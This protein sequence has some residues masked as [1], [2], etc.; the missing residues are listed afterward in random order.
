MILACRWAQKASI[1]AEK[2]GFRRGTVFAKNLGFGVGFGYRNNTRKLLLCPVRSAMYCNQHVCMCFCGCVWLSACIVKIACRYLTRFSSEPI[3]QTASRSVQRFSHRDH[4]VS[5]ILHDGMPF[6][7]KI[8]PS[9]G[10]SGPP[11]NI[12]FLGPTRVLNP[13]GISIGA[14]VFAGF[15]SVTDRQTDRQTDH[16]TR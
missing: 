13:N 5:P 2:P 7:L 10:E 1:M 11:S 3:T 4:T 16:T 6:P 14:A 8:T 15:T 12:W 9:H